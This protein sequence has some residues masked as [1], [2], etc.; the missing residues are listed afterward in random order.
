M[1]VD[2]FLAWLQSAPWYSDQVVHEQSVEPRA[3]EYGELARPLDARL[4]EALRSRDT[5]PLY[6][7]QAA[8]INAAREG[9]HV[10]VATGPASGKSLCYMVPLLEKMR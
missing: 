10:V 1:D 9:R 2:G 3:A 6:R 7:H 8:A 5:Y 4:E